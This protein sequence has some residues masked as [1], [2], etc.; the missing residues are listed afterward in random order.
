MK[1]S[2]LLRD[3]ILLIKEKR[4]L[5]VKYQTYD[6]EYD[7]SYIKSV[8][9]EENPEDIA[10][11]IIKLLDIDVINRKS[12]KTKYEALNS[13]K[14]AFENIGVLIFQISKINVNEMRGFSISEIPYPTIVLNRDD[15]HLGRIFTLIHEFC[16]L[17]LKKGG[18]CTLEKKDEKASKIEQFC[19]AVAGAVLVPMNP[20]LELVIDHLSQVWEENELKIL[21]KMFW[22]N[23][24]VILR[25]LL[26]LDKT[27]KK[28]YKKKREEWSKIPPS[29]RKGGFERIYEKVTRTH[30]INYIKI[31]FN[32]MQENN[33]TIHDVSYYLSMNLKHLDDL[34]RN[35]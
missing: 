2:P 29:E 8:N 15:S 22:A 28:F 31:V 12:W 35:L 20:L 11:R 7:Y 19:N 13:W 16:H 32:A 9:I 30:P 24:E 6:R 17:M 14:A 18:I 21:R 25:R 34:K 4:D 27:N 10:F 26:T 5:A 33:I 1:F 3:Q 23:Y